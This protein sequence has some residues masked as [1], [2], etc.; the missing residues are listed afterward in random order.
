MTKTKTEP[1]LLRI[2]ALLTFWL[3][4]GVMMLQMTPSEMTKAWTEESGPV[5]TLSAVGYFVCASIMAVCFGRELRRRWCLPL[6]VVLMGLRELDFH[7]R[8]TTMSFTKIRYFTSSQVPLT[9]KIIVVF[10]LAL[11][12]WAG[13]RLLKNHGRIFW[14]GLKARSFVAI[15]V[16]LG[17]IFAVVAKKLDGLPRKLRSLNLGTP[18]EMARLAQNMEEV[19]K[20]GIPVMFTVALLYY[21]FTRNRSGASR[22][23]ES[24]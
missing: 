10:V 5:E 12:A 22:A 1:G 18:E 23:V 15:G 7:S 4:A 8:M 24:V 13:W 16:L 19:L 20:L 21:V 9:E 11:V 17:I 2:Y 14:E 3:F 6:V